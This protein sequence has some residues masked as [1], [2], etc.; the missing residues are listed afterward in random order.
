MGR[1]KETW[2]AEWKPRRRSPVDGRR[3]RI[4]LGIL[5]GQV[6]RPVD[7]CLSE[8]EWNTLAKCVQQG[9]QDSAI[10]EARRQERERSRE[11]RQRDWEQRQ[12]IANL[13]RQN[14][15]QARV[16]ERVHDAVHPDRSDSTDPPEPPHVTASQSN[17]TH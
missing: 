5:Q 4:P 10:E 17:V 9:L 16:I 8:E 14:E 11:L 12:R 1:H 13:E 15:E 2:T 3:V 7:F 6:G